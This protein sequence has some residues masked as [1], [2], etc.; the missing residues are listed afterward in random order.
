M[1][2]TLLVFLASFASL[3]FCQTPA[4][5]PH[6]SIFTT[7]DWVEVSEGERKGYV[8]RLTKEGNFEEDAGEDRQRP[9][10]YL[11]GRWKVDSAA[12]TFTLSVDGQM[13]KSGV[14]RRYLQ[15]RDFYLIY[16]F[17]SLED[18]KL[19]LTDQLTGDQRVF[20]A[21]ER[22]EYEEPAMRRLP[23]PGK[24]QGGFK[25]PDGWGGFTGRASF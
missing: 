13:G 12:Q 9:Y 3:A 19:V 21:T 4:A 24:K 8:L 6:D 20:M 25:L 17:N 16:D 1:R 18:G 22:K 5:I 14:H 10:R 23:K 7:P 11:M 2:Y 15:G